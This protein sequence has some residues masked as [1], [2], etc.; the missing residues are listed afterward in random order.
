MS[1]GFDTTLIKEFIDQAVVH[2]MD[3]ETNLISVYELHHW[4]I[5]FYKVC[6]KRPRSLQSVVLD[7]DNSQ[8]LI[9]DI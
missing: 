9:N 7:Q 4:G 2:C 3:R 6:S 1:F 8:F 5:G